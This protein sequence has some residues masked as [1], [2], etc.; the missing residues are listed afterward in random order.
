MYIFCQYIVWY[1]SRGHGLAQPVRRREIVESLQ[2]L[3]RATAREV[4]EHIGMDRANTNRRL[5]DLVGEGLVKRIT[6]PDDA[7][8]SFYELP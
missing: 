1:S 8:R 2:A 6:D 3:G 4:A 7:H 5:L